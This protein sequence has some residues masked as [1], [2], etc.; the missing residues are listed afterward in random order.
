MS[1]EFKFDTLATSD[2]FLSAIDKGVSDIP[3][4]IFKT[5]VN[6]PSYITLDGPSVVNL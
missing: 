3:I 4:C 5:A 6:F 2:T 1:Q